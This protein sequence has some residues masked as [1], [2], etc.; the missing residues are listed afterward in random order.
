MKLVK[1][2]ENFIFEDYPNI[3]VSFKNNGEPLSFYND[4]VWD[5]SSSVV[6]TVGCSTK[7]NFN[8]KFSNEK[9]LINN[10]LILKTLKDVMQQINKSGVKLATLKNNFSC[11]VFFLDYM[12][13]YLKEDNINNLNEADVNGYLDFLIEKKLSYN[14]IRE[15]VLTIKNSFF[16]YRNELEYSIIFEPFSNINISKRLNKNPNVK[17]HKQTDIIP[18]DIWKD[19]ISKSNKYITTYQNNI[20]LEEHI[21]EKYKYYLNFKNRHYTLFYKTLN[22]D[23]APYKNREDHLTFIRNVQASCAIII[24]AFTGMRISEL[25]SI[26]NDCIFKDKIN[27]DNETVEILKI[28]G[29][30][31]KYVDKDNFGKESGKDAFWICP[32]IVENAVNTLNHI[33]K[34]TSFFINKQKYTVEPSIFMTF[35][36]CSTYLNFNVKLYYKKFLERNDIDM[37]F[38]PH[39][40]RRTFARFLAR[41]L[42]EVPIETIKEQFKHYSKHITFYYMREDEKSDIEFAELISE[43]VENK[44]TLDSKYLFE[45]IKNKLD[46]SIMTV[47]NVDELISYVNGN[48]LNLITEFMA[49]INEKPEILSPIGCLTCNG[50]VIIPKI[51]LSYWEDLL[52]LYDEMIELEPNSI[53]HNQE[54]EMIRNVVKELKQNKAYITGINK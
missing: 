42:I 52:V 46:S 44:E 27:I 18:D 40:F 6:R 22:L 48:K 19:I 36:A 49:S 11:I 41:S 28:K 3:V 16:K 26:K 34:G 2:T 12:H 23:N 39:S 17:K 50:N 29:K 31:Y 24:Q 33:N 53:W 14:T 7:L 15:R 51:H 32:P 5:Y 54:R 25:Q 4:N 37:D 35:Q 1:S 9:D 10:P 38:G 21:L 43:Y 8:Q 20:S 13:C 47:N 45:E 30:T